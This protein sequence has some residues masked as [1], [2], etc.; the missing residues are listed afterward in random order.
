MYSNLMH[1]LCY[2]NNVA[3]KRQSLSEACPTYTEQNNT[4]VYQRISAVEMALKVADN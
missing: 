4:C 2:N 3:F 1:I